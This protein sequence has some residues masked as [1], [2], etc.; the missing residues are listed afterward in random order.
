[1]W[2]HRGRVL[3]IWQNNLR[4]LWHGDKPFT[5][6]PHNYHFYYLKSSIKPPKGLLACEQALHFVEIV[7]STRTSGT[8]GE[9][10]HD[11][12]EK[13]ELATISPW[14][15][16]HF[17][18]GNPRTPQSVKTVITNVP[19]ACQVY[20]WIEMFLPF[21]QWVTTQ[22]HQTSPSAL[23][24]ETSPRFQYDGSEIQIWL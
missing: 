10:R 14:I 18:L 16:F 7:K 17:H 23:R 22:L 3:S 13:G 12:E 2:I 5:S 11:G 15:N 9:S 21:F 6:S 1:M 4:R 24:A 19:T 20:F 8:W